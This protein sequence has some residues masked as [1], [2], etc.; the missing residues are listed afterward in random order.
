ME[1]R[2]YVLGSSPGGTPG[3]GLHDRL[4][5]AGWTLTEGEITEESITPTRSIAAST[6]PIPP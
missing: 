4:G 2:I 5:I 6:P 3:R 1:P